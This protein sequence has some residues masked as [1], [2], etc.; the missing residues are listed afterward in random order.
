M[1]NA[2]KGPEREAFINDFL[3]AVLPPQ[4]RFGT[5]DATDIFGRKSGQLDVV[6]ELPFAPSLPIPSR[7]DS[8]LYVAEGVAA[9]IEVKSDVKNQWVE[10]VSTAEKLKKLRRRLNPIVL[11][12]D[13]QL[14][15]IPFFVVGYKGWATRQKTGEKFLKLRHLLTV[16]SFWI[17]RLLLAT[18]LQTTSP[19]AALKHY[20]PS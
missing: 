16:S 8:R 15:E 1:S 4:Y 14:E 13:M 10:A 11:S 12:K 18:C 2:T 7:S 20:G 19:Q 3:S 9:V 5:G 6:V 17:H